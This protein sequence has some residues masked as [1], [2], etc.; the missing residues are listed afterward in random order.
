MLKLGLGHMAVGAK[1]WWPAN[2]IY[3]ADFQAQRYMKSGEPVAAGQAFALSRTTPKLLAAPGGVLQLIPP[4]TPA[5]TGQ[6]LSLEPA[7]T[8]LLPAIRHANTSAW[9]NSGA[10]TT[11][12][13]GTFLGLFNDAGRVVSTSGD[14]GRRESSAIV[15]QAGIPYAV[16]FWYNA[17]TS[18]NVYLA[19]RSGGSYAV[20][21][22][23]LSNPQA[24]PGSLGTMSLIDH[25]SY[26]GGYYRTRAS[27]TVAS[28]ATVRMGSGPFSSE[29]LSI[30]AL[31]IQVETGNLPS[32][33]L[34]HEHLPTGRTADVLTLKLPSAAQ[35]VLVKLNTGATLEFASSGSDWGLPALYGTVTSIWSLPS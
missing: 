25:T 28:E 19:A 18:P 22:G 13:P 35:A 12:E 21:R 3:A 23:S 32:S 2:A 15:L 30:V 1:H 26:S 6:G 29:G 20:L 34:D 11:P 33:A 17:G 10:A 31:G 24:V 5:F 27:L 7:R 14:S 4:D 9:A 8:N 16:T